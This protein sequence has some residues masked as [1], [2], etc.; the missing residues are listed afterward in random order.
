MKYIVLI[1]I[2]LKVAHIKC[3]LPV[4]C[5]AID[6]A[7][8]WTFYVSKTSSQDQ[9]SCGHNSPDQ[10]TGNLSFINNIIC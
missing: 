9:P 8:E 6:I 10:N 1:L 5:I 3:D 7:G 2:I 4:H